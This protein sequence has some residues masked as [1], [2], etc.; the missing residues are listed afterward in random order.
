MK[1]HASVLVLA[2]LWSF[3]GTALLPARAGACGVVAIPSSFTDQ[4]AFAVPTAAYDL[5]TLRFWLDSDGSGFIFDDV[6]RRYGTIVP[7]TPGNTRAR[8]PRF[9]QGASIPALTAPE[10]T[11]AVLDRDSVS[12]DPIFAGLA[13]QLGASW[14]QNRVWTFDYVR[15]KLLWR[16][17]GSEP[18]HSSAEEVRLSF[19]TDASG[20]LSGGLQYPQVNVRIAGQQFLAS[21][22][23]AATVALSP[24]GLSAMPRGGAVRA[25]TFATSALVAQWRAQHPKWPYV[26]NAGRQS[27]ISAIMIPVVEAGDV[28]FVNVWV[29]TRPGDDVFE[30][31]REKIKLGPTAFGCCTLTIDYRRGHAIVQSR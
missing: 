15:Q 11:L 17:D 16:C 5:R 27:D 12:H 26:A 28:R 1:A 13:G 24:A 20:K 9:A 19:A 18:A 8:L 3:A 2:A 10:G 21:L 7:S 6:V 14:L 30:G 25:T 22:D 4:R 29:T 23:T 31:E